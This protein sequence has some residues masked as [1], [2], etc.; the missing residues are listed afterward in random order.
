MLPVASAV[1]A[2]KPALDFILGKKLVDDANQETDPDE[3]DGHLRHGRQK[4]DQGFS[5]KLKQSGD[6]KLKI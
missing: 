2:R 3:E 6:N 1:A 5:I 4:K